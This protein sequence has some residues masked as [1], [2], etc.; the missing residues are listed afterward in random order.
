MPTIV[1]IQQTNRPVTQGDIDALQAHHIEVMGDAA[2]PPQVLIN[3]NDPTQIAIVGMVHDLDA[4]RKN[5]RGPKAQEIARARDFHAT[6][7]FY[8]LEQ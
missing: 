7:L 4:M 6:Q 8:F 3:P 5:S 1:S 2:E